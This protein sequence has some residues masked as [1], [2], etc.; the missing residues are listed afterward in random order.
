MRTL[1]TW[2]ENKQK[3]NIIVIHSIP[4]DGLKGLKVLNIYLGVL[5]YVTRNL[6][7]G[8]LNQTLFSKARISRKYLLKTS[9]K[10]NVN[11]RKGLPV[12]G[13]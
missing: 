2:E 9:Y 3:T 11:N 10:K 13:R 6:N 7:L 5:K 4:T 8:K 12:L 1:R